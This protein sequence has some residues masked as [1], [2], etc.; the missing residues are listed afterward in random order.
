M[1]K[2][3][4]VDELTYSNVVSVVGK[5]MTI[6]GK[7]ISLGYAINMGIQAMDLVLS[8]LEPEQTAQLKEYL[9]NLPSSP[10]EQDKARE[11]IFRAITGE[12][13]IEETPRTSKTSAESATTY[14]Q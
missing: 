5:L 7:P 3:I 9:R 10:A 12:K 11:E 6:A 8:R 14:I 1:A 13:T 4:S 2:T